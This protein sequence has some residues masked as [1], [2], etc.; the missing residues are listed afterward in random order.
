MKTS[1]RSALRIAER[2]NRLRWHARYLPRTA[3]AGWYV[4]GLI[5]DVLERQLAGVDPLAGR[6]VWQ[7]LLEVHGS[8][9]CKLDLAKRSPR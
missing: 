2:R 8:K 5:C 1:V 6:S 7:A 4:N 9:I 3:L